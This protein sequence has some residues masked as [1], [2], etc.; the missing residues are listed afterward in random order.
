MNPAF[1]ICI[2]HYNNGPTV[3]RSLESMLNQI[4]ST[5]EIV[6]VDNKSTD[7][8]QEILQEYSDKG[9]LKLTSVRCSRGRGRE[10]A[11]QRSSGD[12]IISNLDFD[13]VFKPRL[14]EFLET[15]KSKCDGELLWARSTDSRGFWEGENFMISP[16]SLLSRLGGWRDLQFGEDWEL[17]RRAARVGSYRWTD[18]QLLES[19]NSHAERKTPIGR[20][21]FRY[22]RYRDLLRCG[23][24]VFKNGEHVSITQMVPFIIAKLSLPFYDCYGDSAQPPFDPYDAR[25]SVDFGESLVGG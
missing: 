22:E 1:S 7:G 20:M 8:S 14:R 24:S 21:R 2:T 5:F 9:T 25:F 13:D 4:D 23:R 16:R 3:K 19:M 10:I 15:Y 17:A 11:F 12:Y 18:F 6:V